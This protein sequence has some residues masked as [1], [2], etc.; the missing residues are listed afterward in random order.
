M[1]GDIAHS[2][3][4]YTIRPTIAVYA[5]ASSGLPALRN[6]ELYRRLTV[7]PSAANL[8]QDFSLRL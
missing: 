5:P 8:Q 4:R 1:I 2:S 6:K 3:L 7:A